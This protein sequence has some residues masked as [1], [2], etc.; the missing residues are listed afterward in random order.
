[1]R[2]L[3]RHGGLR[4]SGGG[5]GLGV[6]KT[7]AGR[8]MVETPESDAIAFLD[9]GLLGRGK[10]HQPRQPGDAVLALRALDHAAV[11]VRAAQ[12]AGE[13]E[14]AAMGGVDGFHGMSEGGAVVRDAEPRARL[15][16]PR[17]FM[18]QR[19][20]QAGDAMAFLGRADQ[21]RRDQS[22]AQIRG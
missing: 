12:H 3:R 13:G 18:A 5:A 17:R 1:M 20:Q 8:D 4:R 2:R 22:F 11:A 6:S 9:L 15:G 16:D 10:P 7:F 19:L 21:H 14:F